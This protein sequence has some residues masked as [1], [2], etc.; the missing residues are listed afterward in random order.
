MSI[1][2]VQAPRASTPY[3]WAKFHH[4]MRGQGFA[5]EE[6]EEMLANGIEPAVTMAVGCSFD[7]S[8]IYPGLPDPDRLP[9]DIDGF[10][11]S[12]RPQGGIAL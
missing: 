8:V 3:P 12:F 7:E 4:W 10:E 1:N 5:E 2:I 6:V 11:P 9:D